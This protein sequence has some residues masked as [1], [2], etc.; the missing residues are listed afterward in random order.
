M[1]LY[2]LDI[3]NV[4][5]A[6]NGNAVSSLAYISGEEIEDQKTGEIKKYKRDDEVLTK[7]NIVPED[8]PAKYK[9]SASAWCNDIE[10]LETASNART[11][12]R[13]RMALPEEMSLEEQQAAV[14]S[15]IKE[16]LTKQGYPAAYAIHAGKVSKTET[17]THQN[18]HVHILVG[19]RQLIN[20]KWAAV[21]TQKVYRLDEFGERVPVLAK[22]ED[23]KPIPILSQDGS[24]KLDEHGRPVWKQHEKTGK[25]GR[26]RKQ[27]KRD[28]VIQNPLDKKSTLKAMRSSWANVCNRYLQPWER[29]TEKSY[30]EQGFARIPTIHE[31]YAARQMEQRGEIS[32]RCEYNRHVKELNRQQSLFGSIEGLQQRLTKKK[33]R[34]QELQKSLG[35]AGGLAGQA[36]SKTVGA[37]Q[38]TISQGVEAILGEA[39]GKGMQGV[40]E[41]TAQEIGKS[42]G[43]GNILGVGL[44]V[45]KMPLDI[46]KN[47]ESED[48]QR[49]K[50]RE[51]QEKA[52]GENFIPGGKRKPKK[53]DKEKE[54]KGEEGKGKGKGTSKKQ[55]APVRV[56]GR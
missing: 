15:W 13:I 51:E 42:I 22:D 49:D 47:V 16:N 23:G 56:R 25:D 32:D 38:G 12:K 52:D 43:Q 27:W 55:E 26:T 6:K 39:D 44:A 11:A 7:K 20:G 30:K 18:R 48:V 28:S 31:G 54:G 41:R 24:Q 36:V 5:R 40:L 1:S 21:K 46:L 10:K 3:S 45:A 9:E 14:E 4:S 35:K 19:N 17:G 50:M 53:K 8:A 29:I 2:H 37:V 34:L 33:A